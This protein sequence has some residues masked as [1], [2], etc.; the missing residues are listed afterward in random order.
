VCKSNQRTPELDSEKNRQED[1][2]LGQI[3]KKLTA[4]TNTNIY[5]NIIL[6]HLE[7]CS[8]INYMVTNEDY[9]KLQ[10][11][12]NQAFPCNFE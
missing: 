8:S 7:N 5:K 12:Q 10:L 6:P 2:F 1:T 9:R 3:S 4:L 11:L